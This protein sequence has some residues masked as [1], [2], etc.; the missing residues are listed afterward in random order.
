MIPIRNRNHATLLKDPPAG[1]VDMVVDALNVSTVEE[2]DAWKEKANEATGTTRERMKKYQQFVIHVGDERGRSIT[3]WNLDVHLKPPGGDPPMK[4]DVHPYRGDMSYRC[5]HVAFKDFEDTD[6]SSL[7]L[8]LFLSSGSTLVGYS[9]YTDFS[10]ETDQEQG[11]RPGW[12]DGWL[13]VSHLIRQA[14]YSFFWPFTTTLIEIRI[15]REPLPLDR[16]EP[17]RVLQFLESQ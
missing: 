8:R 7:W 2:F 6:L 12:W 15:N 13:N 14:K 11:N 5:F 4:V 16:T 9:G 17:N 1:L 10:D 3:D